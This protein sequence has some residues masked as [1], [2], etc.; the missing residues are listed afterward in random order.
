MKSRQY[1]KQFSPSQSLRACAESMP[2]LSKA[3]LYSGYKKIT[4]HQPPLKV[5]PAS[6]FVTLQHS[7]PLGLVLELLKRQ[8]VIWVAG[9]PPQVLGWQLRASGSQELSCPME[10]R[11]LE[12]LRLHWSLLL[13][14][15][16]RCMSP[17]KHIAEHLKHPQHWKS[18]KT[19]LNF[20][21]VQ[22]ER[23][24]GGGTLAC[25]AFLGPVLFE[26]KY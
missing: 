10:G 17:I 8:G 11:R 6:N 18:Q 14:G 20:S 5:L 2:G 3:Q 7:P 21:Q 23:G 4:K 24:E 19:K 16:R 25:I 1:Q 22:L 12:G 26:L 15:L 9:F 13:A